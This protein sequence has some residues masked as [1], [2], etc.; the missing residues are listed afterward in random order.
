MKETHEIQV[1]PWVGKEEGMVIT[2]VFL[3]GRAH[4]KRGLVAY[5]P[6]GRLES[7]TTLRLSTTQ[8]IYSVVPVAAMQQSDVCVSGHMLFSCSVPTRLCDLMDCSTPGFPVLH[9]FLQF[10]Q[11]HVHW[12]GDAIQPSYPLLSPSPTFSLSQHQGLFQWL[13]SSYQMAKVSEH[14]SQ[15]QSFQWIFRIDFL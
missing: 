1:N 13:G 3:P 14:Q 6:R 12:A 2:P 8:L 7:D 15:H 4:G 9:Y 5:S 10:A 11:T